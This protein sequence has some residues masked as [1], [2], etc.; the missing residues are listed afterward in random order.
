MIF[1]APLGFKAA[2]LYQFTHA[3]ASL[4]RSLL[5]NL[6]AI[7][8]EELKAPGLTTRAGGCFRPYCHALMPLSFLSFFVLASAVHSTAFPSNNYDEHAGVCSP[9]GWHT[10]RRTKNRIW[11]ALHGNPPKLPT[12]TAH[13]IQ[14][15]KALAQ[16]VTPPRSVNRSRPSFTSGQSASPVVRAA[17]VVLPIGA[18]A[19]PSTPVRALQIGSPFRVLKQQSPIAQSLRAVPAGVS[20]ALGA[21]STG[22]ATIS[23]RQIASHLPTD[24]ES[25][26]EGF[27]SYTRPSGNLPQILASN[28]PTHVQHPGR[29]CKI[30]RMPHVKYCS[31]GDLAYRHIN[32]FTQRIKCT[33]QDCTGEE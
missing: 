3:F 16:A 6:R 22:V 24:V 29:I 25:I 17:T 32:R 11:K 2:R 5:S 10:S 15:G 4:P 14:I 1:G 8:E 20:T 18:S 28:G 30:K 7:T 12:Q 31:C 19:S 21:M 13:A 27:S 26:T 9:Y 33:M 23:E